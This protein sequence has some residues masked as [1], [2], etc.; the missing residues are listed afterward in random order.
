ME[1]LSMP[2]TISCLRDDRSTVVF[3]SVALLITWSLCSA[4]SAT[5]QSG[6]GVVTGIVKDASGAIVPGADIQ[7]VERTTGVATQART[8]DA[9][10]YRAPYVPPGTYRI[11]ASLAG[12][13]TAVADNV[14]VLV[15]Q[16]VTVDFALEVGQVTEQV[17]VSAET[18]LLERSTSE[19]GINTTD[20]EVHTW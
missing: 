16:T 9:G 3:L 11:T 2:R 7:I 14:D 13:K 5:A 20:K 1:I 15:G 12:F 10:V 6:R 17:T 18:P 8:T 4:D 19:I